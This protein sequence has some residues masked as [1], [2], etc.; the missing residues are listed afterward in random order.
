MVW[1][2][3]KW[4]NGGCRFMHGLNLVRIKAQGLIWKSPESIKDRSLSVFCYA[5]S[6]HHMFCMGR[7]WLT[8]L[9]YPDVIC[10][11]FVVWV[12]V[13][14]LFPLGARGGF[15]RVDSPMKVKP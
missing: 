15:R 2:W 3:A 1:T 11:I 14:H 8:N 4:M 13:R 12:S 9:Q 5:L 6:Y 7:I 10:V